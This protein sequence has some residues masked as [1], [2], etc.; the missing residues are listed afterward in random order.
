MGHIPSDDEQPADYT[1]QVARGQAGRGRINFVAPDGK[2]LSEGNGKG[3]HGHLVD[4]SAGRRSRSRHI[5]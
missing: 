5:G 1:G 2:V 4:R 3:G